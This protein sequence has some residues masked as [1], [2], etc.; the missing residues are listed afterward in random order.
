MGEVQPVSVEFSKTGTVLD[1]P[2]V[3]LAWTPVR[4]SSHLVVMTDIWQYMTLQSLSLFLSF[5]RN[6]GVISPLQSRND[7]RLPPHIRRSVEAS[8][9]E[10]FFLSS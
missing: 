6:R 7:A 2:S 9:R 3:G 10:T 4:K 5:C 1:G 8:G